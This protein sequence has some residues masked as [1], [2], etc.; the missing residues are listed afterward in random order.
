[1]NAV[2]TQ[3]ALCHPRLVSI[4]GWSPCQNSYNTYPEEYNVAALYDYASVGRGQNRELQL[5][6]VVV[7]CVNAALEEHHTKFAH[8]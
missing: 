1:M 7:Q 4:H 8:T 5:Q 3:Y 2:S 6:Q